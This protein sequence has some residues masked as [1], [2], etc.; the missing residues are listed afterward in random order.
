MWM[1]LVAAASLAVA[2]VP[3]AAKFGDWVVACDNVRRCEAAGLPPDDGSDAEWTLHVSRGAGASDPPAVSA[4]N[5]FK[6]VSG[7]LQLRIDG[8]DTNFRFDT[9]GRA[10]GD[11]MA[12]L[13]AVAGAGRVEVMDTKAI[14]VGTLPVVGASAALRWMDDRQKRAGTVTAILARGA[15]PAADVPVAPA[16]PRIQQ[17]SLPSRPPKHLRPADVRAIQQ[18]AGDLCDPERAAPETYRLD[19][20][21]TLGIVGCLMG[22]YQGAA[23]IVV[24]DENGDWEPAPI[25]QPQ[26][27]H[28]YW[29]P[30]D[31]YLLTEADYL[32]KERLLFTAAKGRGIADCGSSASWAW[33]GH[34]FRLA[35]Y[36]ALD[37]CRGAP[38]GLWLSRWQTANDPVEEE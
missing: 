29:E 3:E 27:P 8:R 2:P 24:I 9:E 37:E 14:T 22:A 21:H 11:R 23:L 18:L 28:D 15:R 12:L 7:A 26:P 6:D 5:P 31:A 33:D 1:S 19:S 10:T 25:E 30:Y 13:L 16:L 38:P 34:M 36:R 20:K 35:S 32:E 17:P 4:L